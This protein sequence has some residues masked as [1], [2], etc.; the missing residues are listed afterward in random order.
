MR[1]NSGKKGNEDKVKTGRQGHNVIANQR[2]SSH[3][4]RIP[5]GIV[6]GLCSLP[7]IYGL[8]LTFSVSDPIFFVDDWHPSIFGAPRPFNLSDFQDPSDTPIS[9][10]LTPIYARYDVPTSLCHSTDKRPFVLDIRGPI[11]SDHLGRFFNHFALWQLPGICPPRPED[12]NQSVAHQFFHHDPDV[13]SQSP[14]ITIPEAILLSQKNGNAYSHM[15]IEVLPRLTL[16]PEPVLNNESIAILMA[17]AYPTYRNL[18]EVLDWLQLSGRYHFYHPHEWKD[19]NVTD[20]LYVPS[21]DGCGSQN[22]VMLR[23]FRH[24]VWQRSWMKDQWRHFFDPHFKEQPI[25]KDQVNQVLYIAGVPGDGYVQ[26][27][28]EVLN[29]IKARFPKANIRSHRERETL[30]EKYQKFYDSDVIIGPHGAGLSNIMFSR[31][32]TAVIELMFNSYHRHEIKHVASSLGMEYHRILVNESRDGRDSMRV[33]AR[34]LNNKLDEV[35]KGWG[36]DRLKTIDETRTL[37]EDLCPE[38]KSNT[39]KEERSEGIGAYIFIIII[40]AGGTDDLRGIWEFLCL[41][42]EKYSSRQT[43]VDTI[44]NPQLKINIS[45]SLDSTNKY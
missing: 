4:F 20:R 3:R 16:L 32:G 45:E 6:I 8:F 28:Q 31:M 29:V 40:V 27:S 39:K 7:L 11:Y 22:P 37:Y 9:P 42:N 14:N 34:D 43:H 23:N 5:I 41:Q 25:P 15:L 12:L 30:K 38:V 1:M 2:K 24:L 18:S 33:E 17:Q 35:I 10:S 21:V 36:G 19:V 13:V 44:R 26:N